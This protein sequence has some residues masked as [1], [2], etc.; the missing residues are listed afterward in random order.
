M[1]CGAATGG[2]PGDSE[3]V[4]THIESTPSEE[5]SATVMTRRSLVRIAGVALVGTS[6]IG[7]GGCASAMDGLAAPVFPDVPTGPIG[8]E[9]VAGV[10]VGTMRGGVKPIYVAPP[11]SMDPVA[12]SVADT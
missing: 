11:G 12:H 2:Q 9:T 1:V 6:V 5:F 3:D 7:L 8:A 10:P 4:M